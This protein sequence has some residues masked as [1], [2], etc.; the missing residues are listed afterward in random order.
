MPKLPPKSTKDQIDLLKDISYPRPHLGA[1]VIGHSCR[2]YLLY[3]F[4]WAYMNNIE[5]K[6]NR[7]FRIG[8]AIERL[9]IRDL[10]RVGIHVHDTKHGI[11]I[12]VKGFA[13][14]GGGSIDGILENVPE[15]PDEQVLFECKSANHTNF[16]DM[17]RKGVRTS[18]PTYYAQLQMYMGRLDL[19]HALF[20]VVN[21]NTSD[22][23]IEFVDFDEDEYMHLVDLEKSVILGES[24]VEFPKVSTNRSW[25]MCKNC[26]A[27]H[28][29]H[30]KE[31]PK[32]NCRTCKHV[33][34]LHG[35]FWG[36]TLDESEWITTDLLIE[37]CS[38]WEL[39]NQL[40]MEST[41]DT[42]TYDS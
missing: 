40:L 38:K 29:C 33:E 25:Y 23:H 12:K 22:L 4:R 39:N 34:I 8:D 10:R 2:R 20:A 30:D 28:L 13:G 27:K 37:G 15:Y 18:K 24:I 21:K 35:G 11:Q 7:I 1:S 36:C 5:S 42:E 26:D 16:T 14:H 9:V 17:K 6:L 41:N 31:E 19:Q 3:S 32:K